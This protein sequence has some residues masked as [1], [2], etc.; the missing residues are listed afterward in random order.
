MEQVGYF[1][2]GAEILPRILFVIEWTWLCCP[3]PLA[4]SR[5]ER[6]DLLYVPTQGLRFG[7]TPTG[8]R[9]VTPH[10]VGL[11]TLRHYLPSY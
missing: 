8:S 9:T 1:N 6:A 11:I 4:S 5:L 3:S 10:L 7:R 2:G